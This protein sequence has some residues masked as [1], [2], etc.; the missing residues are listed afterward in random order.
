MES[1]EKA[2]FERYTAKMNANNRVNERIVI[3]Q[4][5][6]ESARQN[7]NDQKVLAELKTA[8]E[9]MLNFL[10]DRANQMGDNWQD[11]QREIF[12]V[13]KEFNLNEKESE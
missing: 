2:S 7:P 9:A 6:V 11:F 10:K 5:C 12:D 8:C 3:F 1:N 4:K 13:M